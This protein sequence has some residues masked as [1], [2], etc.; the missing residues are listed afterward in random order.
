MAACTRFFEWRLDKTKWLPVLELPFPFPAYY[1]LYLWPR[2]DRNSP[3]IIFI[4]RPS[5][6]TQAMVCDAIPPSGRRR[7]FTD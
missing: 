3:S 7:L 1:F 5:K 6:L 4:A 2:G